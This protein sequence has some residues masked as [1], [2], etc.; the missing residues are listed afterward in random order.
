MIDF[1]SGFGELIGYSMRY[2]LEKLLI[3]PKILANDHS[4]I[5]IGYSCGTSF[6]T[7]WGTWV[8]L[9]LYFTCYSK[10][11]EKPSKA[12]QRYHHVFAASQEGS[13]KVLVFRNY[14]IKLVLF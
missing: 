11:W 14:L 5:S 10:E 3:K 1:I 4:W 2:I 9:G 7:C 8:D 13:G 12:S 6:G